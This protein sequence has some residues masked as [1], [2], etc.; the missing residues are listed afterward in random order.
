MGDLCLSCRKIGQGHY[1]VVIY[2]NFIEILFLMLYVKFK[3]HRPLVVEKK[4]LLFI[5]MTASLVM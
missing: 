5:A 4:S 3:D 1:R 2:V